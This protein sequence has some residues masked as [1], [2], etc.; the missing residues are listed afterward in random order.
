M[1]LNNSLLLLIKQNPGITYNDIYTKLSLRYKNPA[2][3][4]SALMR[5]LKDMSSFGLIKKDGLK[6]FITDKG[7]SSMSVEMKDKLVL[8]LNQGMKKPI[9]NLDE[10]VKLLVVLLQRGVEDSDLLRNAKDNS[11]FTIN[12]LVELRKEIKSKRKYLKK[13]GELLDAQIDKLKEVDFND[14]L[15]INFDVDFVDK[16]IEYCNGQKILVET[17]DESI[18][19]KVPS[20]W[21]KQSTISVEGDNISLLIQLILASPWAKVVIYV[22]GVK[23]NL[24]AGKASLFGS[25]KT[26]SEF[27]SN[28]LVNMALEES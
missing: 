6:F 23:I 3:A 18:L 25:H 15:L 17:K 4:K 21:I 22:P 10:V 28:M 16:L 2:S 20:H 9:D 7:L 24:M 19:S 26:I 1:T 11:S 12:D 5:G 13:M 14:S 8:K 27:Y